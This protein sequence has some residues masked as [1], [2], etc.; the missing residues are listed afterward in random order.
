MPARADNTSCVAGWRDDL[1]QH[2]CR[3]VERPCA[4]AALPLKAGSAFE[5]DHPRTMHL[6]ERAEELHARRVVRALHRDLELLHRIGCSHVETIRVP[7]AAIRTIDENEPRREHAVTLL[8]SAEID[9]DTKTRL[10]IRLA[11]DVGRAGR[12]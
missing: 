3:H 8:P 4:R 11:R 7:Q 2:T 10:S 1:S 5:L 12:G 6:D 9:I